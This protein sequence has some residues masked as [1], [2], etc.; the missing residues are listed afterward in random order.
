MLFDNIQYDM[1][2]VFINQDTPA[3][4]RLYADPAQ[5]LHSIIAEAVYQGIADDCA[6][7][8]AEAGLA[9]TRPGEILAMTSIVAPGRFEARLPGAPGRSLVV[10]APTDAEL[11]LFSPI[12]TG[13]A[14]SGVLAKAYGL[15]NAGL[16]NAQKDQTVAEWAGADGD[17]DHAI[18]AL[19]GHKADIFMVNDLSDATITSKLR[20]GWKGKRVM[21]PDITKGD[22]SSEERTRDGFLKRHGFT[23]LNVAMVDGHRERPT[24]SWS[25]YGAWHYQHHP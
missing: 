2:G 20:N 18:H 7:R 5:P 1:M 10:P 11:G 16:P 4:H 23:V 19:T 8:A 25:Q 24:S 22:Y 12:N 13:G 3:S 17:Q 14:W 21:T 15:L 9:N 6:F